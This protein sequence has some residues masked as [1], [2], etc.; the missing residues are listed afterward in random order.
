MFCFVAVWIF[1]RIKLFSLGMCESAI[2]S[3]AFLQGRT[4][5]KVRSMNLVPIVKGEV[6]MLVQGSWEREGFHKRQLQAPASKGN[7]FPSGRETDRPPWG[8]LT[9]LPIFSQLFNNDP[10]GLHTSQPFLHGASH[11]TSNILR[12]FYSLQNPGGHDN[13]WLSVWGNKVPFCKPWQR[14]CFLG[15]YTKPTFTL[16]CLCLSS[17]CSLVVSISFWPPSSWVFLLHLAN[18][19]R[20]ETISGQQW[21]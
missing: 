13:P 3:H 5:G 16:F 6:K 10:D 2:P 11:I 21:V 14:P 12:E 8:L 1:G 7:P 4:V 9:Y 20:T 17:V 15:S 19:K 18:T